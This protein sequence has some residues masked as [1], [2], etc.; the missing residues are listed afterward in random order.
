MHIQVHISP[1][2]Y[3][4]VPLFDMA[5]T[6]QNICLITMTLLAPQVGSH[7]IMKSPVPYG[8]QSLN[9]SPLAADGS[10]FPCKLRPGV[11][12]LEGA[13]NIMAIGEYQTLSFIGSA[14]HGGGSCQVALTADPQP[15]KDSK[16]MVIK[17]IEGGCPANVPG[18]LPED[19]N[20]GGASTFQYTVPEGIA[21]G[22][23]T[24]AWTWLNKIGNREFYMNCGP[25][26]VVAAKKRRQELLHDVSK[27]QNSLPNLFVAN[28]ASINDCRT[29]EGFDYLYPNPGADVEQSGIGPYTQLS[30][31]DLSNTVDPESLNP[32]ITSV[33][34]ITITSTHSN[35]ET[36][37]NQPLFTSGIITGNISISP[38]LVSTRM[39]SIF[40]TTRDS[41]TRP[42][43]GS[44]RK[45]ESNSLVPSGSITPIFIVPSFACSHGA[46]DI[47][48]QDIAAEV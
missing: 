43:G 40:T 1:R 12:N 20:G 26:T 39:T 7:M 31:G 36:G 24:I 45:G 4:P 9:N 27:R 17:S 14:V 10:D 22:D 47:W 21:P 13:Q 18:N 16:W 19:P 23:Y 46:S 6:I 25:A 42:T 35:Q 37:E 3:R 41:F 44:T 11:Y 32:P 29:E 48:S 33:T 8:R 5:P 38:T 30:C 15:T 28:L 34:S 2:R